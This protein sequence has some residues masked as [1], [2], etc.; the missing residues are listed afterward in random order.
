[1]Q[2]GNFTLF[3]QNPN[4]SST[5]NAKPGDGFAFSLRQNW[6]LQAG[7]QGNRLKMMS[8]GNDTDLDCSLLDTSEAQQVNR[9][10]AKSGVCCWDTNAIDVHFQVLT[11]LPLPSSLRPGCFLVLWMRA[12]SIRA[13]LRPLL[14]ALQCFDTGFRGS[15]CLMHCIKPSCILQCCVMFQARTTCKLCKRLSVGAQK[16]LSWT[17]PAT[18]FHNELSGFV[19]SFH[20]E[21]SGFSGHALP[22]D[23]PPLPSQG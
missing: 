19:T 16:R 18:S 5:A 4:V 21:L 13:Q 14:P 9:C 11:P 10:A 15:M 12:P 2:A 1:M 8:P 20:N 3:G 22:L 6:D 23:L 7:P 17:C